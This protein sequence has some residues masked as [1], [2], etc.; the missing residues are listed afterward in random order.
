MNKFIFFII[1]SLILLSACTSKGKDIPGPEIFLDMNEGGFDLD[2][3]STQI[4]A[5]KITYDIDGVY[6]WS[7]EGTIFWDQKIYNFKKEA[8][9]THHL[10]FNIKTPYGSDEMAIPV[11]VLHINMFEEHSEDLND[12][13]Y[14]INPEAGFFEYK[15]Y[16]RYPVD[17]EAATPSNWSGFA[18]SK[19]TNKKDTTLKNE[20][21]VYGAS[22]TDN[23]KLFTIFKQSETIDHRIT[24]NDGKTH[25]LKSISINNSTYVYHAILNG[26]DKKE[27]KDFV[28]LTITG[29][30]AGGVETGKIGVY[31]ADYRPVKTTD[32]YIITNWSELDLSS[33]GSVQ[34]I[35]LK[36]TSSSDGNSNFSIP[37][38]VC[39]DNLKIKN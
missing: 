19:N 37:K 24:F 13:G 31:L 21:S 28:L 20:F 35:G 33:L 2:I 38:Y 25:D 29:Y 11:H 30:D 16:I 8:L 22:G 36:V 5:P 4:I 14:F 15:N 6:T 9:N 18:I 7:E 12:N 17:Y 39:L 23:S 32:K 10:I 34:S 3:D 1:C 27:A 26:F